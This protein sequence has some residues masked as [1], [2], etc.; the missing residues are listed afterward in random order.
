MGE[1]NHEGLPLFYFFEIAENLFEIALDVILEAGDRHNVKAAA[2]AE[3]ISGLV[4]DEGQHLTAGFGRKVAG[5][6]VKG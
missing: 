5:D 2:G 1:R 3:A 4:D 6:G